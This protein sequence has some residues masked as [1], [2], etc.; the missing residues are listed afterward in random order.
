MGRLLNNSVLWQHLSYTRTGGSGYQPTRRWRANSSSVPSHVV[1]H[2][3]RHCAA[4]QQRHATGWQLASCL[5]YARAL[6]QCVIFI[7]W[8]SSVNKMLPSTKW[9]LGSD[10]SSV[11]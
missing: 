2:S 3:E 10:Q 11:R 9:A 5:I 8:V 1:S 6:L 7:V 4:P